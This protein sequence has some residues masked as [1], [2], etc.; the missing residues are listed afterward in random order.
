MRRFRVS[1]T[2]CF[3]NDIGNSASLGF[4]PIE[5]IEAYGS[6]IIN[7]HIKDRG[8]GGRTVPLGEGAAD[9]KTIF[10]LMKDIK[11]RG[12]LIM[13][14]ARSTEGKHAEVLIK[15]RD[16]ILEWMEDSYNAN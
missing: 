14:T 1:A 13:Q 5:E 4:N 3:S 2:T 15:Y 9:F 16:M 12:N 8:L 7:I 10:S 6:R 11:Y